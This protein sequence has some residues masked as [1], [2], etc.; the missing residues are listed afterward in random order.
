MTPRPDVEQPRPFFESVPGAAPAGRRLLLI[1]Y[2]FPPT[3]ASGSLRWQKLSQYL[4]ERD[5]FV[6]VITLDPSCVPSPDSDRLGDLPRGTRVFGVPSPALR[7]EQ[8]I[9]S[10]WQS[11]RRLR[12]RNAGGGMPASM[13]R[14]DHGLPGTAASRATDRSG[15]VGRRDVRWGLRSSRGLIRAYSAW[16]HYARDG[17]WARDAAALALRVFEPGVHEAVASSGPPHMTHEA[18][19]RL[20]RTTGLPFIM[21]MRD[22]WSLAERLDEDVASP[23]WL[24]LAAHHE[25]RA[26]AQAA[27]IVTNTEPFRRAMCRTHPAMSDRVITVMNGSDEGPVPASRAGTRF[28]LAYAGAIYLDRDPRVLFRAAARVIGE[29]NL[30]PADFGIAFIGG[31]NRYGRVPVT[32]IAEEE[33]LLGFVSIGPSRPH[34]EALEFLA[35]AT[36]LVSLPQDSDLAI[37]AKIFEYMR[38]DAWILALAT[39][40]SATGL[41]LRESGADVVAP[42]DVERM[43]AVLRERVLQ[44]RQGIRPARIATN[45]RYSR[46][47]QAEVLLNAI[48]SCAT[49][50]RPPESPKTRARCSETVDSARSTP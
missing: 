43:T 25:R 1:S 14:A 29:L 49:R 6:D 38:F 34:R 32:Q 13:T 36:M 8:G 46:R 12:S 47:G 39:A 50:A 28:L 20:S 30:T 16:L 48:A 45:G 19:R 4:A 23:L 35:E 22:A 9:S 37:P 18:G 33:G 10:A 2:V 41:L 7:I 5:W 27:V 11:Y 3:Q 21:D 17:R 42:H 40:E 31:V 26:V 44:H 24:K 15:S